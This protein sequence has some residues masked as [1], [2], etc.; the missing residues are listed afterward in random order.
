[1]E[2][3]TNAQRKQHDWQSFE[4][5]KQPPTHYECSLRN[6]YEDLKTHSLRF[7]VF[8]EAKGLRNAAM[9]TSCLLPFPLLTPRTLASG[10][11]RPLEPG[12]RPGGAADLGVRLGVAAW[13]DVRLGVREVDAPESSS[14]HVRPGVSTK[15]SSFANCL[16]LCSFCVRENRRWEEMQLGPRNIQ[17]LLCC[18]TLHQK[19]N[20]SGFG[21]TWAVC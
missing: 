4:K 13:P 17:K 16:V 14:S 9:R 10:V 19:T 2:K 7:C 15:H 5:K 1:M 11:F 8:G 20:K 21:L 3:Q 18:H 12:V 6:I